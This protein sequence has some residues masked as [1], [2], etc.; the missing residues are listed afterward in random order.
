MSC[1][2]QARPIVARGMPYANPAD[3]REHH[4]EYMRERRAGERSER[5]TARTLNRTGG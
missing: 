2:R 3:K 5:K 1:E 4:R